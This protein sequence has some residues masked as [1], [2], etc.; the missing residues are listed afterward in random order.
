MS[1]TV[2]DLS[3]TKTYYAYMKYDSVYAFTS[4]R[5]D[6]GEDLE[7]GH[8]TIARMTARKPEYYTLDIVCKP[9]QLTLANKIYG[10]LK[11]RI[12]KLNPQLTYESLCIDITTNIMERPAALMLATRLHKKGVDI[13]GNIDLIDVHPDREKNWEK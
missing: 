5:M 2:I 12:L 6:K 13:G 1:I 3:T 11:V 10:L 7:Y 8:Q 9:E 4:L